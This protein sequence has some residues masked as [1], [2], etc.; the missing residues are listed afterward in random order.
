M[1]LKEIKQNAMVINLP[2]ANGKTND[3]SVVI[4]S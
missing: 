2:I 1:K 4:K 3:Q